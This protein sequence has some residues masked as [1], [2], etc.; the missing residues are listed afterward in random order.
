M[1]K[2]FNEVC[3]KAGSEEDVLLRNEEGVLPLQRGTR[4][5]VFGRIQSNYIRGGTGSGGLVNVA[6]VV[7]I[8]EGL[9][10]AGLV[11]N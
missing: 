10:N 7:G 11:L 2:E 8:P 5:S 3:R 4:V 6:Y 9:R 1:G